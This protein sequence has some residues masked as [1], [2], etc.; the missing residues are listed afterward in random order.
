[1]RTAHPLTPASLVLV[2]AV[3]ALAGTAAAQTTAIGLS[4]VHAQRFGNENLLGFYTPQGGDLFAW[5]LASGDFNGDG[6]DDV[7]TGMPLDN[8]LTTNPVTDS[9]TVIARYGVPGSGLD[10][11]PAGTVLRQTADRDPA[12]AGDQYGY[13]LAACDFNGDGFDD[14]AVGIPLENYGGEYDAGAVQIHDGSSSGIHTSGDAFFTESTASIA[15]DV[16]EGDEFG[17]VLACGDFDADG[18][19]DLVVGI[20]FEAWGS[21]SGSHPAMGMIAVIPGSAAGLDPAHAT[22]LDQ[23][24]PGMNGGAEALDRFGAA[25]AAGDFDGDLFDDLAIGVPGED[26][27]QGRIQVVFGGPSGLTPAGNLFWSETTV[28]GIS[29]Q[30]DNFGEALAAGD[31]D[32]DGRDDLAIGVPGESL[33]SGN[34]IAGAGQVAV[35]FGSAIGFDLDRS[36]FLDQ[37]SVLGTGTS[38]SGDNFGGSVAVADFDRDGRD[39]LAVGQPGEFVSGTGDGAAT[40]LMGSPT[41]LDT[42]RHRGIAAGYDGFPGDATQHQ[43]NLAYAVASGDFDG[44]GHGDLV[45]G[46][47]YE[48]VAGIA[49]VGTEMVLYG[50]LFADGA[51]SGNTS[52]WS[53]TVSTLYRNK[54]LATSAARLGPLASRFGLQV[55]LVNP[56]LQFPATS[57]HVRVGPEAGFHDERTLSGTF[58]LDPQGLTMS[59]S[60][61]VNAFSLMTFT[62]GIGPGSATRLAFELQR[63]NALGGWALRA[64][65]LNDSG[66]TL[67]AGAAGFAAA[68]PSDPATHNNRIDFTWRAGSPGH[69]TMWRTRFTNGAPDGARQPML[70]VALPATASAVI[71]HVFAGM[72]AG[73]DA[74]TSGSLFLDEL[75]FRR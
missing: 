32:G 22:H 64:N 11:K 24:V 42:A 75:S 35:L 72:V 39:D 15:G 61:G 18:F 31:F 56:T 57:T 49:D 26:D 28:G 73:Q 48:N 55:D 58:F 17:R 70:D 60:A 63:N 3:L 67:L 37:D 1:M 25:L 20:P 19:D 14:L 27:A 44:D 59:T 10:S 16:E 53:Q 47:P 23:D 8:G 6:A 7:A 45:L 4:T 33:G 54:I 34:S 50:A 40:V 71:N 29:E 21:Q 2:A 46:A 74:G 52:L 62:D 43:K 38:E 9:G 51:E 69:L 65:Y 12:E 66:A 36:R 5:S 41:G 30:F 68:N 13:A